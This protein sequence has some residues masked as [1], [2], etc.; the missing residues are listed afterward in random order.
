MLTA[1]RHPACACQ[2]RRLS[3]HGQPLTDDADSQRSSPQRKRRD[4][5]ALIAI[6]GGLCEHQPTEVGQVETA[7]R[8]SL[9][10]KPLALSAR[11]PGA[12][13]GGSSRSF[14]IFR[15][16]GECAAVGRGRRKIHRDETSAVPAVRRMRST[17]RTKAMD[18]FVR[19]Y[20][21][22]HA[23][24]FV[25]ALR[26]EPCQQQRVADEHRGRHEGRQLEC[27]PAAEQAGSLDQRLVVRCLWAG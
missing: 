1:L 21:V 12:G 24:G 9:T 6:P 25:A 10:V 14:W 27:L 7:R 22:V 8:P 3:G 4:R 11:I 13:I 26:R 19:V 18:G 15:P 17:Q 23:A 5:P 16:S 2:Q 20:S